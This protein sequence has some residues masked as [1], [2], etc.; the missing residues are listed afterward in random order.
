[1][2]ALAAVGLQLK[3]DK[4]LPSRLRTPYRLTVSIIDPESSHKCLA[5]KQL[6]PRS[7]RDVDHRLQAAAAA[8]AIAFKVFQCKQVDSSN[9][10]GSTVKEN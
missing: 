5:R 8:A 10:H 3:L 7:P 9:P 2:E 6:H 4:H 1:M